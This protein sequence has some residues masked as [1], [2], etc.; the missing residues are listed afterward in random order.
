[1]TRHRRRLLG[2]AAFLV[3]A[4]AAAEAASA[5]SSADRPAPTEQGI[6]DAAFLPAHSQ[7]AD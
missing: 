4:G 7:A 5:G 2:A 3:L 6:A 1:M